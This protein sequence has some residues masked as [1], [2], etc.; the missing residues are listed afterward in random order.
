MYLAIVYT[1]LL[2]IKCYQYWPDNMNT[3]M[4]FGEISVTVTNCEEWADYTVRTFQYTKVLCTIDVI[5]SSLLSK[6]VC[7]RNNYTWGCWEINVKWFDRGAWSVILHH[8]FAGSKKQARFPFWPSNIPYNDS[9]IAFIGIPLRPLIY[10]PV[11]ELLSLFSLEVAWWV[12]T[13]QTSCCDSMD[14][15]CMNK[16][17]YLLDLFHFFTGWW[18]E[19]HQTFLL[20]VLAWSWSASGHRS[21]HL[22]L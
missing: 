15:K 10:T 4:S 6:F 11:L 2:Q 3:A 22:L 12:R 8:Q 14:W 18:N 16:S 7:W 21:L 17:R 19:N 9:F 20:V 1:Y 5:H 13:C